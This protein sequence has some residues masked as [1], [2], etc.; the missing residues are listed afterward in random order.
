[1]RLRPTRFQYEDPIHEFVSDMKSSELICLC[2]IT[3]CPKNHGPSAAHMH[4]SVLD[5]LCYVD[6]HFIYACISLIQ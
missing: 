2:P 4:I 1:M 6:N 3:F 5:Y